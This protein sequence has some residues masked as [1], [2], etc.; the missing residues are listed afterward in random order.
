M[1]RVAFARE[2]SRF[3]PG[4]TSEKLSLDESTLYCRT[5][6]LTHYENFSVASWLLPKRLRQHFYNIYAYCRWADDLSDEVATEAESLELL[7]WW[8][9]QLRGCFEARGRHPV[10][11]ALQ[12]TITEFDIPLRP[13]LDLI[14]AFERD[15]HQTRYETF[16]DL[17]TYCRC[18]ANP[19]GHLV[20]YLGRCYDDQSAA[21]SDSVCTGLQ[22]A[23]FLQDVSNDYD[24]G[25]VYLPQ[26]T[27]RK[28]GYDEP[29]F[30]RR[31]VDDRWRALMEAECSRAC[32]L[33]DAGWPLVE[34]VSPELRFQIELF[35]R[36]GHAILKEVER[37]GYDVWR[38]R[39]KVGKLTKVKIVLNTWLRAKF[40]RQ[41]GMQSH[42]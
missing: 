34:R 20:L 13:F 31:L 41:L 28:F 12:T 14:D 6:A 40:G 22:L 39:P 3:G 24:R 2:L 19:V 4:G 18:S 29:Q 25:R 38:K 27:C 17:L 9:D 5:L 35:I 42:G 36:G 32:E 11:I 37:S 26:T 7:T 8:R 1:D 21:L 16:D 23:N 30:A 33:L 10:F 15:Q